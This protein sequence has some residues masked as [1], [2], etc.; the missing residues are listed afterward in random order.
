MIK[1]GA[2]MGYLKNIID[3]HTHSHYSDDSEMLPEDG[4][5]QAIDHGLRGLVFTDHLDI[6]LPNPEYNFT[7]DAKARSL[8]L[9]TLR[10][11]FEGKLTILKGIEVGIQ[12]HVIKE[13]SIFI[14]SADF[15]FVICSTHSVDHIDLSNPAFY[16]NKTHHHAFQRYLEEIYYTVCNFDSFDVVG[17]IGYI[18][19]YAPYPDKSMKYAVYNDIIDAILTKI[20][21]KN[22]GIEINTSGWYYD[23]HEPHPTIDIIKRYKELGGT[24]IT[25]GSDAHTAARIGDRFNDALAILVQAG[26]KH[27]THFENRKPVFTPIPR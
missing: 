13:S 1:K 25:V 12:P 7:F 20:I 4:C 19:R 2:L 16:H 22:R 18:R 6:D 15:D 5:Q 3:S 9:D 24:I 23:L 8:F 26:F 10:K 11:K 27:V 17:H 21:G 14:K